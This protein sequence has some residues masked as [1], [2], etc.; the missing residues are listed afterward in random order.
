MVRYPF[1]A[2]IKSEPTLDENGDPINDGTDIPF[3]ADFQLRMGNESVN[4][5]GSFVKVQ[6]KLFVTINSKIDFRLGAEVTCN[7]SKG[8]IVSVFPTAK[9]FEIWVQ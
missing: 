7:G 2:N 9:N 3:N 8:V 5:A 4:Y 1:I 6:Y